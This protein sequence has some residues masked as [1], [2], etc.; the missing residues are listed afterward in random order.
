MPEETLNQSKVSRSFAIGIGVTEIIYL[1]GLLALATGI[2]L[3]FGIAWA[4]IAV[5]GV[6]LFTA[7][8]NAAERNKGL[9]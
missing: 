5:G 2:C 7:F 3:A 9:A 6:L 8:Q 4:L 1:L